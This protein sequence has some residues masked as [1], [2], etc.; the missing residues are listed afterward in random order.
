MHCYG[1]VGVQSQPYSRL[2]SLLRQVSRTRLW[3]LLHGTISGSCGRLHPPTARTDQCFSALHGW[4]LEIGHPH[5]CIPDEISGNEDGGCSDSRQVEKTSRKNIINPRPIQILAL[6]GSWKPTKRDWDRTAEPIITWCQESNV[7]TVPDLQALIPSVV[8]SLVRPSST[9]Q[10]QPSNPNTILE[11]A[12]QTN[13]LPV[14]C[15]TSPAETLTCDTYVINHF[16]N[17]LLRLFIIRP[18]NTL[19]IR[20]IWCISSTVTYYSLSI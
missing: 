4:S 16:T 14:G 17:V 18:L 2:H 20:L 3:T 1:C 5:H 7:A 10:C 6:W 9:R 13:W 19:Y 12:K 8:P 11:A 15:L